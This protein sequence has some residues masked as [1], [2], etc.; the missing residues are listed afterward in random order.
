MPGF[1]TSDK[2][3]NNVNALAKS[4]GISVRNIPISDSVS[5]HL[6][7]ISHGGKKDIT[8]ENAQARA[9]TQILMDIA[10][11]QNGFVIGT[12]D[13]SEIALGWCTY[14]GD[15]ISM[16]GINSSVPKTLVKHLLSYEANKQKKYK[17]ALDGV[18]NTEISPELLPLKD[19]KISQKTE[20]LIGSYELHDFFLYY[21]VRFGQDPQKTFFLAKQA[22]EGKFTSEEIKKWLQV[23]L[24]RFFQ[25]QFKRN[26]APDG[27]KIGSISL[28]PRADWR[29]PS[30]AQVQIWLDSIKK[31]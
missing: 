8:Y 4:F 21:T 20:K 3:L 18:L 6:K 14:N 11:S 7:D 19:G 31:I 23:F 15:H 22:F 10:N 13:L 9:R 27:V 16:Y 2:T 26:C 24:K 29:M 5:Q 1:G 28:S 30:E 25:N 17:A 12:G